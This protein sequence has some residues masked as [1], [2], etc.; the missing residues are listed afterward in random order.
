MN[1]IILLALLLCGCAPE[2]GTGTPMPEGHAVDAAPAGFISFCYRFQS[3]CDP[4]GTEVVHLDQAALSLLAD[5]NQSV[6]H[7]IAPEGGKEH[8]GVA[9]YWNIP[10]D[11]LGDCK[12]YA[13][14][15]RHDLIEKGMSEKA[16]RLAIVAT[17]RGNRHMVL[18]VAS[19]RGD[20]VL[21]NLSDNIRAW[22]DTDYRWISRQDGNGGLD[23]T[24]YE[25]VQ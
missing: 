17:P 13:L 9:E 14:S 5:V 12:D 11:G 7:S 22:S 8:Y 24:S 15:K 1:R 2:I 4:S 10:T 18:T 25:P 3:E 6:N 16:L 21:D 23:W 19:D 20:F